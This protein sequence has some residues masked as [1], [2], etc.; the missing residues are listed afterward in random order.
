MKRF[1]QQFL[2]IYSAVLSTVFAVILLSG[3]TVRRKQFD[4]IQVH[5]IDVVEPDGTLR[6]VISN[7]DRLPPMIVKGKEHPELGE[8]RPQAGMIFYNDEGSENGGLIFSGRQN[9]KGE[10]VDSGGSLSFDKYGASQVVQ[11]AGVDDKTDRF[12][13][14]AISDQN[15]RVWVGRTDDGNA[16]VLLMDSEG[17][18]RIRMQ[19]T[20]DG[21]PTLS[22]LDEKGQVIRKF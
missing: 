18:P 1:G 20:K 2:I 6:M 10:I 21:A 4:E 3:A 7:K 12:A 9:E 22:F 15:R 5:R 11:L 17:R 13:G 19:V 8:P 14:L 16:A